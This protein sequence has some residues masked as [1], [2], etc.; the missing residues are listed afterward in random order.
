[1]KLRKAQNQAFLLLQL[2][3]S[4]AIFAIIMMGVASMMSE[5]T[6]VTRKLDERRE[7]VLSAQLALDRIERELLQ[8][9]D[10]QNR[11][12]LTLFLAR[13]GS[14]GKELIFSYLDSPIRT[15]FENR[16][17]GVK[18]A[19]YSLGQESGQ[20]TAHLLRSEVPL[21]Q[22]DEIDRATA[23]IV[24][25]GI[26]SWDLE[27]YNQQ[28]D[29]WLETWDSTDIRG[30]RSFPNAVRIRIEAVDPRVDP[31]EI[32]NKSIHFRTAVLILNQHREGI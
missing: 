21:F 8:A 10:E 27:F 32:E 4:I 14:G 12:G 1:M 18:I 23:K 2:I 6:K 26:V 3:V 29:R 22:A 31:E 25:R 11:R 30:T 13:E 15:L 16:T 7:S 17:H 19:A 28:S 5:T 9:F 20:A 24:A